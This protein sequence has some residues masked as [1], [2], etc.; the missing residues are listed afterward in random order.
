MFSNR[1]VRSKALG[2]CSAIQGSGAVM[3]P[4]II[5]AVIAAVPSWRTSFRVVAGVSLAIIPMALPLHRYSRNKRTS[6]QEKETAERGSQDCNKTE[7]QEQAQEQEQQQEQEQEQ[8][9]LQQHCGQLEQPGRLMQTIQ[10]GFRSTSFIFLVL[11]FFS[12]G[13]HVVFVNTHLPVHCSDKGLPD[14]VPPTAITMIGVGNIIGTFTAGVLGS[15]FPKYKHRL[16]SGIY[17]GRAVLFLIFSQLETTTELVLTFAFILGLLWLS[18]VP[19]TAGLVFDMFG[20]RYSST[21]FGFAFAS[22]QVIFCDCSSIPPFAWL[23]DE[24]DILAMRMPGQQPFVLM[25][26]YSKPHSPCNVYILM[27][28]CGVLV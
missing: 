7:V 20:G 4:P 1:K 21:M 28:H 5:A 18:T 25:S 17:F 22:H 19:L 27:L 26:P 2:I 9:G 15:K 14:W 13:F 24:R 11:G 8:G 6:D 10:Y 12:C 16:L 23:L 3:V